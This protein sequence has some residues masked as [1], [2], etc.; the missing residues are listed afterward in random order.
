MR[1]VSS[2]FLGALRGSHKIVVEAISVTGGF[3]TG[4]NPDGVTLAVI[5]GDVQLDSTAEVRSTLGLTVEG[6]Q[7]WP[8]SASDLLVPYGREVYVRRGVEFGNGRQEWVG[9]GYHRIQSLEQD[10]PPDGP[11]VLS[12]R[13]RMAGIIDGRLVEP[14]QFNSGTAVGT[15][16]DTLVTEI[17]PD[18]VVEWDDDSSG[19]TLARALVAEESRFDFLQELVTSAG[20][21]WY[22]DHRGILM[23]Q[24]V[25]DPTETVFTVNAGADGVLV[26]MRRSLTREKVY[27]G[28]VASG[29]AADTVAP[30]RAVAVDNNPD[31]PTYWEGPFGKVP[32]FF[33]SPFLTTV[34]QAQSAAGSILRKSLGL[35]Y[36]VDFSLVPNP[37]LEPYDAVQV[38]YPQRSRLQS[39]HRE[40][41]VLEKITIPLT[42]TQEMVADTREQTAVMIG[43]VG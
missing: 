29:E 37:A 40:T 38:V 35:P 2:A 11:I 24:D 32:R 16:V 7:G 23:I 43:Q 4:V 36:S 6:T 1:P 41:H 5:D 18:A 12:C 20:K 26:N 28:V 13:D 34:A 42:A 17:Y 39:Y 8:D 22:W 27:N 31:S 14:V 30:P 21:I 25:P 10:E 3:Q 15:I 19:S 9:L 33:V